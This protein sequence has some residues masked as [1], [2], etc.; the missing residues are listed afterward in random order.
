MKK[1]R[2]YKY[3]SNCNLPT[4]TVPFPVNPSLQVQVYDP[5]L[6]KQSAFSLHGLPF[7]EHSSMSKTKLLVK[8]KISC[9]VYTAQKLRQYNNHLYK[10]I[11]F[12]WILFCKNIWK[13]RWC[14]HNQHFRHTCSRPDTRRHLT[15]N[16]NVHSIWVFCS[17]FKSDKNV[18]PGRH[19]H[20][21]SCPSILRYWLQRLIG[22]LGT[23]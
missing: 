16:K 8:R 10:L 20:R 21:S 23:L 9:Q 3:S 11:H 1:A 17:S 14:W 2:R 19:S 7:F 4:Q 22:E 5:S 12:Q 18:K 13:S 15:R 6:F